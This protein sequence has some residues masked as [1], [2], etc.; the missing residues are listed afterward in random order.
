MYR[1]F[2]VTLE[3]PVELTEQAIRLFDKV[4]RFHYPAEHGVKRLNSLYNREN[5]LLTVTVSLEAHWREGKISSWIFPEDL[6][7]GVYRDYLRA[8]NRREELDPVEVDGLEE[9]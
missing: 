5:K 1:K 4:L 9:Y 2:K 8:L 3:G 6:P 7:S